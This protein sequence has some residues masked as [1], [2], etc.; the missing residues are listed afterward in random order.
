MHSICFWQRYSVQKCIQFAFGR[1]IRFKLE[2]ND[3]TNVHDFNTFPHFVHY[4]S[5]E[6]L[7]CLKKS[8]HSL[9]QNITAAHESLMKIN[10]P[11]H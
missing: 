1:D 5:F 9:T 11:I 4:L 6:V 7:A 8:P 10:K 3:K 2:V